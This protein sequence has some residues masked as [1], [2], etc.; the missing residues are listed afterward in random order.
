MVDNLSFPVFTLDW[1]ADEEMLLLEGVESFGLGNWVKVA[2]HV[3]KHADDCRA[4]YFSVYVETDTFPVPQPSPEMEGV[5]IR[6]L[7][8]DR[9][10]A[11]AERIAL[12][13][14]QSAVAKRGRPV[15]STDKPKPSGDA[16]GAAATTAG[17]GAQNSDVLVKVEDSAGGGGAVSTGK[18]KQEGKQKNA[19]KQQ[20]QVQPHAGSKLVTPVAVTINGE[21]TPATSAFLPSAATT[22]G[23]P[24]PHDGVQLIAPPPAGEPGA[25]LMLSEAQ[26]TGYHIKRNEFDPEYDHEAE[27]IISE[28]DFPEDEPEEE[29]LAK[30]RLIQIYNRRL[31]ERARRYNFA[32][33]RG[34]VNVKRQ[35]AIDRRRAPA[36]R[37]LLGRLR[38]ISRYLPQPQWEA[39]AEGVAA[40]GRLR[41][42]IGQLQQYRAMGM[43]TF[44]EVEA[45]EA[46]DAKK[47]K[48]VPPAAQAGKSRLQR[49]PVDETAMET[50]LATLGHV[51]AAAGV[52]SQHATIADG[53]GADGLQ[54]WRTR[55]GVL[56]DIASLPDIEPLNAS[57][58]SLCANQRY[59]PAQ[60]LCVKAEAM[61]LQA[62]KGSVSL[63]D[64]YKM[65]FKVSQGRTAELHEFFE[66]AGWIV[67]PKSGK[68]NK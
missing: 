62:E 53:R 35:S 46:V 66:Q 55:R 33:S 10:R 7:I 44:E 24:G 13:R 65:P 63:E 18:I 34:L 2:E 22:G 1:G 3:G 58:R 67:A 61:R 28:L 27:S 4:H 43:R 42:R 25:P 9:R 32:L 47:K 52:H 57:E 21:A 31:D 5:D 15:V 23:G 19:K 59:L 54:A 20:Q 60:Y 68:G 30:L 49:I 40:E 29:R 38:V 14:Q 16:G 8:E 17:G 56:L 64:M 37:E 26:Q 6:K 36:E 39:L 45:F 11:G 50:E 12:A 51:H 48:E 41:A